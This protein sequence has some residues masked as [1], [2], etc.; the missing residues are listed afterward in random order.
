LRIVPPVK[1][2]QDNR[3]PIDPTD[4]SEPGWKMY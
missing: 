2:L 1:N 3:Q 4:E